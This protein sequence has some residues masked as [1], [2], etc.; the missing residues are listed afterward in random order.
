M[1]RQ[2]S[3]R[4]FTL[5]A[6]VF[7]LAALLPPPPV[8]ARG[9]GGG[10]RGGGGGGFHF[11]GEG[12]DGRGSSE[13]WRRGYQ[14]DHPYYGPNTRPAWDQKEVDIDR[15]FYNRDGNGWNANW[16]KGGYWTNR[17]W[18]AGWYAWTP[19]T[20]GWWGW[21]TAGWGL[22]AVATGVTITSLVNEAADRQQTVI[23]VPGST[24]LLNYASV[25]AVGFYGASFAYS[26]GQ[27]D[28]LMGSAN[29]QAGLLNGQVPATA[30]QAQLLN[31]VCQVAYGGGS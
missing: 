21:N 17:P 8:L 24:Y 27:T 14:G 22:A 15:N 19:A 30:A 4:L 9:G 7:S 10:F 25:E 20:W 5:G 13:G 26:L 6:L 23:L 11:G 28:S 29:C 16:A 31:A 12:Y 18:Q 3:C 2:W 1:N